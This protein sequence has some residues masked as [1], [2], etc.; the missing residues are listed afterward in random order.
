VIRVRPFRN[1][2]PPHLVEVWRSQPPQ[3]GLAQSI[4]V[5]VLEELV[6]AKPYFDRMGLH[7]A[8]TAEGHV[9]GFAHAGFGP[10]DDYS[11]LS[12]ELGVVCLLLVVPDQPF[13]AVAD[14]LLQASEE[15]LRTR[16]AKILYAGSV[17]PLNPFYLG[18]YGG[19]ELPGVLESDARALS[20]YRS[21]GYQEIDRVAV[22]QREL[23]GF[24][25]IVDRNQMQ[26]R[27]GFQ[28]E[29]V[30]DPPTRSWWESCTLGHTDR[31]RFQLLP[32][33]G[34]E[35][36]A[37]A[38]FWHIEPLAS[39]WGVHAVGL[40]E[41]ET[42]PAS[43]RQGLATFLVGESLRQMQAH[44]TTLVEAQTM[45]RNSAALGLYRKL[46]FQVIDHG[47]VL[48]KHNAIA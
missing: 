1:S 34:K 4:S 40:I 32:R 48:R 47:I 41:V 36:A 37:R 43:R 42:A 5:R 46:G 12:T 9:V 6:F 8:I 10:K 29:A 23:P 26:I 7:V 45:E 18:L 19:S 44:G 22:M 25:P 3:R 15:F 11:S 13:E 24:R 35:P 33:G 38:T 21:R 14:P 31:T 20:F 2:D 39:S 17:F 28:V 27:R 30:L 16:G